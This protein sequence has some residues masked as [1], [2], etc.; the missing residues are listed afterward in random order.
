LIVIVEPQ[1]SFSWWNAYANGD[2][3]TAARFTKSSTFG[4]GR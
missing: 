3:L 1:C 2:L 4:R